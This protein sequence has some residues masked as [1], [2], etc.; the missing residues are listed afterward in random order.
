MTE[1]ATSGA[2][3]SPCAAD[4]VLVVVDPGEL[5]SSTP[6]ARCTQAAPARDGI[7]ALEQAGFSVTG[8]TRFGRSLVCRIDDRPSVEARL[9]IGP[10]TTHQE[11]C[12]DTPPATAYWS[13]WHAAPG[14][15]TWIYSQTGAT[16]HTPEAAGAEGWSFALAAAPGAAPAPSIGPCDVTVS[17]KVSSTD[18][19]SGPNG[20]GSPEGSGRIDPLFGVVLLLVMI[21]A[22]LTLARR[23]RGRH[24]QYDGGPNDG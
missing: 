23:R 15:C 4:A 24:D 20:G 3:S 17:T 22:A 18:M 19:R 12:V 21:L 1:P 7:D 8:T 16:T 2:G 14:E 11:R 6:I 5:V 13:Y 10:T 9:A